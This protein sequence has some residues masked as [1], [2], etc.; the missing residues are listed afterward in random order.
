MNRK[1]ASTFLWFLFVSAF[2]L[3]A[4][5]R[6]LA[7]IGGTGSIQGVIT[8]ATGAVIPG[9]TVTAT[10][11]ATGVKT[12]RQTTGAGL[13]VIAPLPPGE[14]KVAVTATGFRQLEQAG[15]VVDALSTVGLNL[16]LQVGAASETVTITSA[17]CAIEHF[18]SSSR[19]YDTQRVVHE[20]AA[21][22]GHCRR[23]L[24]HW[25]GPQKSRRLHFPIAR[26]F[27]GKSLG[28]NQWRAGLLQRC[29]H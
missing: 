23:W 24:G 5:P 11:V 28:N 10:N 20:F 17:P 19:H 25:P 22:D 18:R 4:A 8:D 9:A 2:A 6:A 27:G 29:F 26:S 13:Y 12:E 21:G 15:V 16:T 1:S 3:L 7:Q 14:Y